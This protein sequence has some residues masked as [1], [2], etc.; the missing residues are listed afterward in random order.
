M[1]YIP[2]MEWEVEFTAEFESWWNSLSEDEQVDVNA[3]VILLQKLGPSLPRPHADL[4]HSS[5]H[6]NM[7]ELR[8]QHSGRPYRVLFAFDPRRSAIL[9]IGGDKT[10]NDR[11]YEEFVPVADGL[12]DR[13]LEAL[14]K[15]RR[16]SDHGQKLQRTS[17]EDATRGAPAQRSIRREDD[18]GN[19]SGG[20]PYRHGHDAGIACKRAPC[21]TGIDLQD[22]TALGYVYQ[23]AQQDH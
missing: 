16:K 20:T 19:G 5:R 6:A 18:F 7:K 3:K 22:G 14:K 15:D 23:H 11:W 21:Q 8:I 9:L 17:R 12:Y 13:H 4:I 2:F 10:G 1:S